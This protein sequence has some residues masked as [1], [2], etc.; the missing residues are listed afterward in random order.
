[1]C[2]YVYIYVIFKHFMSKIKCLLI[3][4][5]AFNYS[6][7]FL[8]NIFFFLPFLNILNH[9]HTHLI[10]KCINFATINL[11]PSLKKFTFHL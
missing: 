11:I 9:M 1:M 4:I 6:L 2:V 10:Y 5:L 3:H 7:Y 8:F